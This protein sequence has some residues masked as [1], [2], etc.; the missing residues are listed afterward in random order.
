MLSNE[1]LFR[2][3]GHLTDRKSMLGEL[4]WVFTAI[5]DTI[6]WNCLPTGKFNFLFYLK[7]ILMVQSKYMLLKHLIY[8]TYKTTVLL[9]TVKK[10][11]SFVFCLKT[12]IVFSPSIFK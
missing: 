11:I 12:R 9:Q 4:N 5:T 2:I 1:P 10:R 7:E 3:P 6:A 8:L